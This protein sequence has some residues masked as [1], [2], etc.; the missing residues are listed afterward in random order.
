MKLNDDNAKQI[1]FVFRNLLS[2][3]L[4]IFVHTMEEKAHYVFSDLDLSFQ[5]AVDQLCMTTYLIE[6]H[7]T[8]K[9]CQYISE[10]QHV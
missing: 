7:R 8:S 5:I 1:L 3:H 2:L 6:E 10:N 9:I 4:R